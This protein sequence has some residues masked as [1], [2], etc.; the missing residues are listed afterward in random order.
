MKL[1]WNKKF[2]ARLKEL[3]ANSKT[4]AR[5]IDAAC[6]TVER[7]RTAMA[8]CQSE[9]GADVPVALLCAVVAELGEEARSGHGT[10]LRP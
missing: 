3:H 10:K 1:S 4:S 6:V 5:E 9:V 7:L 8:I 2:D